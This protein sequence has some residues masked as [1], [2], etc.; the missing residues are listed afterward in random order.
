MVRSVCAQLYEGLHPY[1][2]LCSCRPWNPSK[3]TPSKIRV[4]ISTYIEVCVGG[5]VCINL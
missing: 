3:D 4:S 1:P 2:L 5:G